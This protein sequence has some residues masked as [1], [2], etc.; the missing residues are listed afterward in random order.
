MPSPAPFED[1]RA[2]HFGHSGLDLIIIFLGRSSLQIAA[3]ASISDSGSPD[4]AG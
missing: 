3:P 4:S 2:P 1:E